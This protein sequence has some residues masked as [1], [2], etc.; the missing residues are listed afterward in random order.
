VRG[1]VR[2]A[3]V[4]MAGA[5]ACAVNPPPVVVTAPKYP[6]FPALVVPASLNPSPAIAQR[7][8]DAWRRLQSGDL[9]GARRDYMAILQIQASF[10]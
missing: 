9:G 8:D 5:A 6:D 1:L 10:Y 2:V 7:H 3:V 4:V